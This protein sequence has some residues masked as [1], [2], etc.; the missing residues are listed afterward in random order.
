VAITRTSLVRLIRHI[1]SKQL[2]PLSFAVCPDRKER[3]PGVGA[4]GAPLLGLRPLGGHGAARGEEQG[5]TGEVRWRKK[6]KERC[7][8]SEQTEAAAQ[9]PL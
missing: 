4:F 2:D 9:N 3:I 1:S 7:V 8:V 6:M 5:N